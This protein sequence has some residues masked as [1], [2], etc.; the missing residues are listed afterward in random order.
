MA[1][2]EYAFLTV[3]IDAVQQTI[4]AQNA[5]ILALSVGGVQS[6]SIDTG[7]SKQTVTRVNLTE[8]RKSVDSLTNQLVTLVAR[9]DGSGVLHLR[10]NW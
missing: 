9:R 7:Q 8:L 1:Y 4:L 3:Q 5:A 6:Y 10:P 2:D